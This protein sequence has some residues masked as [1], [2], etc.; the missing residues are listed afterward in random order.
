MPRPEARTVE[1]I[2]MR[3]AIQRV[4]GEIPREIREAFAKKR[5]DGAFYAR[6]QAFENLVNLF[7]MQLSCGVAAMPRSFQGQRLMIKEY[8]RPLRTDGEKLAFA[9]QQRGV[10]IRQ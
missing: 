10:R 5:L 1:N 6:E 8:V 9:A 2:G 3:G 7:G 4:M